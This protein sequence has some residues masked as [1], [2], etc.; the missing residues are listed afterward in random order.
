MDKINV[1]KKQLLE[2][3]NKNKAQH[4]DDYKEAVEG[5]LRKAEEE[6]AKMWNRIKQGKLPKQSIKAVRPVEYLKEYDRAIAMLEMHSNTH[7]D[8]GAKAYMQFVEDE[9]NWKAH[10]VSNTLSYK[11]G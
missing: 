1:N 10:F 7:I 5:Y 6:V 4:E 11:N 9:W 3:L 2:V 8:L